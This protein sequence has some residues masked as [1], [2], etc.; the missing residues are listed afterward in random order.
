MKK[1]PLEELL[2]IDSSASIYDRN[3]RALFIEMH[4]IYNGITPTIMNELFTLRYQN[5]YNLGNWTYIDVPKVRT[6]NHG[7]HSV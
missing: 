1:N 7:S 6:V 4:E 3:L 2:E 5:Q